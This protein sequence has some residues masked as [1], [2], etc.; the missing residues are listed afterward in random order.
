VRGGCGRLRSLSRRLGFRAGRER[1]LWR[2]VVIGAGCRRRQYHR[3][4]GCLGKEKLELEVAEAAKDR[5][6]LFIVFP[7]P[8]T[9]PTIQALRAAGF[10]WSKLF[11]RWE[12][13][14]TTAEAEALAAVHMG[15]VRRVSRSEELPPASDVPNAAEQPSR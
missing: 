10:R 1:A 4:V 13:L 7:D 5:E 11:R 9:Q 14:A 6:P 2:A 8:A 3:A 15:Q 12:G